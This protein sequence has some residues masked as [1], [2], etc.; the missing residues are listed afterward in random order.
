MRESEP[1]RTGTPWMPGSAKERELVLEEME[2]VV[3]SYHFHSSKRYPAFLKYVVEAVLRNRSGE[4]KERTLGVEI[5]GRSPDYDT[6]ADPI[7][8]VSAAEVRKRIAQYYYE[9]SGQSQVQIALPLGSYL[10]RF[11]LCPQST[12]GSETAQKS[13]SSNTSQKELRATRKLFPL[14]SFLIIVAVSLTA[15]LGAYFY[16]R[17]SSNGSA[18]LSEFWKPLLGSERP[19]L[20]VVGTTHPDRMLPETN[21]TTFTDAVANPY[22]HVSMPSAMALANISALL[23]RYRKSSEIKEASATSLSDIR[24]HSL[25]LV[26]AANNEWTMQLMNSLRMQFVFDGS[27]VA[28]IQDM[29]NPPQEDWSIDRSKPYSSVTRD[30]GL[31]ARFRDVTTGGPVMVI[32][33]LGPYGT[34]AASEFVESPQYIAKIAQKLPHGWGNKNIELVIESDVIGENAGPPVLVSAYTW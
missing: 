33:G 29:R 24:F 17:I 8:R 9:N 34:E 26:G 15:V 21:Q 6:N 11:W 22:H 1:G 28:R 20:V 2:A 27:G 25:I 30:Y 13:E 7:V 10:P 5:F 32:A 19:L 3:S 18:A 16:H 14:L 4:V 23:Q 31:I 12:A